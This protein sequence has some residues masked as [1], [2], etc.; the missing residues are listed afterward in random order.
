MSARERQESTPRMLSWSGGSEGETNPG[1]V[2]SDRHL[3]RRT[4]AGRNRGV[5]ER[6]ESEISVL[7]IEAEDEKRA[8]PLRGRGG[9]QGGETGPASRCSRQGTGPAGITDADGGEDSS[10]EGCGEDRDKSRQ[11]GKMCDS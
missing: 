11:T 7:L 5:R 10:G 6:R 4:G 2:D 3:G 1:A 8:G 9:D